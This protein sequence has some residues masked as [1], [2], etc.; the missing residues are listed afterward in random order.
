MPLVSGGNLKGVTHV[1]VSGYLKP[2]VM[3]AL[4]AVALPLAAQTAL[5]VDNHGKLEL[6]GQVNQRTALVRE[7][8][9]WIPFDDVPVVL[10]PAP[11]YVP[12]LVTIENRTFR[13]GERAISDNGTSPVHLVHA[14]R[15]VYN[16]DFKADSNL[17]HVVLV[18]ML[19][20]EKDGEH[21]YLHELGDL[22]AHQLRHISID[23]VTPY[24]LFGVRLAHTY[25]YVNGR[26]VFTSEI[27]QEQR[28][29][30]LDA[31]V[32]KRV[33]AAKDAEIKPLAVVDPIYPEGL[34]SKVKGDAV[35]AVTVD[36]RGHVVEPTVVS[37]TE[38]A[39]GEAAIRAI[40]EWR[41]VPAVKNGEPVEG[42]ATVPFAF[43]PP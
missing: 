32:A 20:G 39:F 13:K 4:A 14:G 41:F 10:K 29:V 42:K 11:E 23:E 21:V 30:A 7:D 9:K 6:V 12:I 28:V 2:V 26:E 8:G 36:A 15:F 19:K 35:V 38:P 33:A 27:H 3:L 34:K 43:A 22:K 5:F 18:L 24:R 25:L 37:A 31:M 40:R 16:A 17:E 1:F